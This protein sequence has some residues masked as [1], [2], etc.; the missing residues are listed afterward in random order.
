MIEL[1]FLRIF[2]AFFVGASLSLSAT[3]I[4]SIT[5]NDLS[6][7]STLGM[8][9]ISV[10]IILISYFLQMT[11]NAGDNL[12]LISWAIF[13]VLIFLIRMLMNKLDF[14]SS[15][16]L[17]LGGLC[18]NLLVGAIFSLV[19][20]FVLSSTFEFP[21]SIWFGNFKQID[22]SDI[23][24]LGIVF[25]PSYIYAIKSMPI[26]NKLLFGTQFCRNHNIEIK[27]FGATV[28][29]LSLLL[30]FASINHFGVFSFIGLVFVHISK[31]FFFRK[32]LKFEILFMP[33]IG[34]AILS[35]LDLFCYELPVRGIEIPVGLICSL[36]GAFSLL[37]V[38]MQKM[39]VPKSL[40]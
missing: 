16:Y 14:S 25:I 7:P 26:L 27:K 23:L 15:H 31:T 17:I 9:G 28:L 32:G 40:N 20:F 19:Q 12:M 1:D 21:T 35:L 36:F 33:L 34:G 18:I 22:L 24:T 38:T 37:I 13:G 6:S 3:L 30:T 4:Q 2:S 8:D 11:F 5:R 39:R 10:F 29:S